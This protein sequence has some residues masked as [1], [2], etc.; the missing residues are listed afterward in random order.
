MPEDCLQ[1]ASSPRYS[2]R[3]VSAEKHDVHQVVN[4]LDPGLFPG[5]F[6]KVIPD[7]LG[8]SEQHCN[9]IHADGS[10]TKSILA[11]LHYREFG[12]PGVF[13][14]IS[15]DSIVMN[16]DDLLCVGATGQVVLSN[17]L[18]RNARN[19]PGEVI[20]ALIHGSEAFIQHLR[21]QGINIVSGG[22][23]TADV[24]D[25][26]GT[27]TVDSNAVA[28]L[29]RDEVIGNHIEGELCIVG[30]A[31]SGQ[32]SYET[33]ENSGIG[34]NGLTSA[35]HDLLADYYRSA[36]PETFDPSMPEDL[37]YS[38]PY[39][40]EDA[41]PGSEHLK[42]GEALLSP[43]RTYAPLIDAILK[44]HRPKITAL[45]HC[46]GGGQTKCLKFAYDTHIIKDNLF[47]P[48]PIF[49]AIE[50]ASRT[51]Q[52]EMYQVFNMGHR[53]EIYTDPETADSVIA[54]AD[55]YGVPA[56]IIGRT[57]PAEANRLTL[58]TP[59]GETI[60]Y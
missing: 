55:S 53:M 12:D 60:V 41:L 59:S 13:E 54:I 45:I 15:Q 36:Y 44:A 8:G 42:V 43:T 49:T 5:S 9:I 28:R 38:G 19:C 51:P 33:F 10:G 26:T 1:D 4:R 30:L 3:G 39:R 35:R 24:G 22:G 16:L 18:N 34:S 37:C 31:S 23:E 11:Y 56:K 7:A 25:L 48:P 14:G 29:K 58:V 46:S 32:A 50:A 20:R 47:D 17:T 27:I 2:A 52:N 40:L 21:D 6:C 57:E